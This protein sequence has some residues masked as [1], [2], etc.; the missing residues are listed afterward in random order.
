MCGAPAATSGWRSPA[1]I[2]TAVM[3]GLA[4]DT[5]IYYSFGDDAAGWSA[6]ASFLTAPPVGPDSEL[7][8]LA[9]ADHGHYTPD[10]SYEF[11]SYI[12]G[13]VFGGAGREAPPLLRVLS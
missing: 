5:R 7:R 9:F 11:Q 2:N 3:T 10:N 12:T 4:P 6:Q 8:L 13:A 1:T